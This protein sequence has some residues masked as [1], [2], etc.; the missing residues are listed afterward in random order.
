MFASLFQEDV[1]Y[2]NTPFQV[3]VGREELAQYWKRVQLQEDVKLT[4]AI[5]ANHG[6]TG[7]AHWH[8]T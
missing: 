4:Y 2:H 3:Q 6:D 8:V 7:I 1:K 5:L